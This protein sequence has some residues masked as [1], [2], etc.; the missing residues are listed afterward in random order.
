MPRLPEQG[1]SELDFLFTYKIL[2]HVSTIVR[3]FMHPVVVDS[4][5]AQRPGVDTFAYQNLCANVAPWSAHS[6]C[7]GVGEVQCGYF[8]GI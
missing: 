1:A 6:R 7:D 8:S 3:G 2:H 5:S 4:L